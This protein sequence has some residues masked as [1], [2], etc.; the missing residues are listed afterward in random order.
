MLCVS[1]QSNLV[2]EKWCCTSAEADR[3]NQLKTVVVGDMHKS[4]QKHTNTHTHTATHT[5]YISGRVP[6]SFPETCH[7]LWSYCRSLSIRLMTPW[8]YWP[9]YAHMDQSAVAWPSSPPDKHAPPTHTHAHTHMSQAYTSTHT[10]TSWL[11][12]WVC[13]ILL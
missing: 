11:A 7:F 3:T 1:V 5:H 9:L 12:G 10:H 13:I 4:F 8:G 6:D 2:W